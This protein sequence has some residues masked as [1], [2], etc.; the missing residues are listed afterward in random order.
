[1][2]LLWSNGA[3]PPGASHIGRYCRDEIET[4]FE[5]VRP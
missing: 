2:V 1:M 4:M 3:D 5:E